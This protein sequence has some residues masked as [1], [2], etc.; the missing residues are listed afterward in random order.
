MHPFLFLYLDL[1]SIWCVLATWWTGPRCLRCWGCIPAWLPRSRH[2]VD[3]WVAEGGHSKMAL[4]LCVVCASPLGVGV[5]RRRL[6]P[7]RRDVGPWW[8]AGANGV[9][10]VV[11]TIVRRCCVCGNRGRRAHNDYPEG[12]GGLGMRVR[13]GRGPCCICVV[14]AVRPLRPGLVQHGDTPQ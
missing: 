10:T 8:T 5:D 2:F 11:G 13:F 4:A 1:S 14:A 3:M 12:W 6:C 7:H 9:A